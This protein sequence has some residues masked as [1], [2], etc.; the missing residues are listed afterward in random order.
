LTGFKSVEKEYHRILLKKELSE[1]KVNLKVTQLLMIGRM[2]SFQTRFI[3]DG[4]MKVNY[5]SNG[6]LVLF[7][8][9][10]SGHGPGKSNPVRDW[11]EKHGLKHYFNVAGSPDLNIIE[12]C[13]QPPKQYVQ[14][15]PHWDDSTT[16]ELI[17]EGWETVKQESINKKVE[18]YPQRFRDVIKAGGQITGW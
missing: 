3:S 8:D 16:I 5:I 2:Y 17:K 6:G 10:D 15:F 9:G 4:A 11:K 13:W 12:N 7:E 1:Q 14:K 18:T